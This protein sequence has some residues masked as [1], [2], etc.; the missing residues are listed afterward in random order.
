MEASPGG[1]V[2]QGLTSADEGIGGVRPGLMGNHGESAGDGQRAAW[3]R[4][5]AQTKKAAMQGI[6]AFQG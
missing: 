3:W 2:G 1:A 5:G 4:A 6:A